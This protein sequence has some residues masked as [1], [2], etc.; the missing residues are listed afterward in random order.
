M[1]Y[2]FGFDKDVTRLMYSMR[3]WK[4]EYVKRYGGTPSCLALRPYN[5]N[6]ISCGEPGAYWICVMK[7]YGIQEDVWIIGLEGNR[8][9][10]TCGR[11]WFNQRGYHSL[12]FAM[13]HGPLV[14]PCRSEP[15]YLGDDPEDDPLWQSFVHWWDNSRE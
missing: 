8:F 9:V 15:E 2:V 10:K 12:K 4:L 3:D 11:D 1:A 7:R 13:E 6:K 5:I 14:Y